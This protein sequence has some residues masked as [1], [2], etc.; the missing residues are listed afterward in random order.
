M[1]LF[2]SIWFVDPWYTSNKCPKCWVWGKD[3]IKGHNTEDDI[4]SCTVCEYN[5]K[6]S[7]NNENKWNIKFKNEWNIEIYKIIR[8]G[9]ENWSLQ[10]GLRG[11]KNIIG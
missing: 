3:K 6:E 5:G 9:D 1:V 8:T 10:I 11:I 2:N 7:V 4:I